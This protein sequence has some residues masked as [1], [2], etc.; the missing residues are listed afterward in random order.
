[1][2][3]PKLTPHQN[4]VFGR[5]A[6]KQRTGNIVLSTYIKS[7][8]ACIHLR[9]KGV[10]AE[11]IIYGPRGGVTYSYHLTTLGIEMAERRGVMF[12]AAA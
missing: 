7:R 6:R 12:R 4:E 10:I 8:G 2:A 9:A 11:H 5:I 3:T 1:M